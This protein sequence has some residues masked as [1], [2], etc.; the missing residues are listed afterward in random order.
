MGMAGLSG[1]GLEARVTKFD[2]KSVTVEPTPWD[3]QSPPRP[4]RTLQ[5]D[6]ETKVFVIVFEQNFRLPNGQ[7]VP[8]ER[9]VPARLA[10]VKVGDKVTVDTPPGK[11]H[12]LK[13]SVW[14]RK[15]ESAPG[16]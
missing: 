1:V 3:K 8:Y 11:D 10:D 15:I 16:L 5:I 9:P 14:P 6:G 2:E 12:A 4:A 7:T 13:I